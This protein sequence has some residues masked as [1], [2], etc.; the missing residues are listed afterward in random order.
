MVALVS[1]MID[2]DMDL[3]SWG[4]TDLC[5]S[6]ASSYYCVF[7]RVRGVFF[8][9]VSACRYVGQ[10]GSVSDKVTRICAELCVCVVIRLKVNCCGL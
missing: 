6:S 3:Q 7:C 8:C 9:S 4:W 1:V 10:V 5:V 2:E